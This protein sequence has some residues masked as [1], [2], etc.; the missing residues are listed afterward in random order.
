MRRAVR[1]SPPNPTAIPVSPRTPRIKP[2][3]GKLQRLL[4]NY[5]LVLSQSNLGIT[6]LGPGAGFGFATEHKF[7]CPPRAPSTPCGT[8]S[9][10]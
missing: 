10:L 1:V 3:E 8:P 4:H 5:A 9:T 2:D 6:T 7:R